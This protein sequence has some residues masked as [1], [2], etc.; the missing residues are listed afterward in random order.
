MFDA[1]YRHS[2]ARVAGLAMA[3]TDEQLASTVAAT[4]EWTGRDVVAHLVGVASDVATGNL[5][6][7][8]GPRWT[9]AQVDARAGR[10]VMDL[11]AE[12]D[13]VGPAMEAALAAR[14]AGIQSVLDVLTH[15]SD[16]RETFGFGTP[17]L[18][19]V[20]AATFPAIKGRVGGFGGPGSLQVR[21]VDSTGD[22]REWTGGDGPTTAVLTVEPYELFRGL[23][24]RR[25]R[26]QMRAWQWDG[27]TDPALVIEQ[28]P[29]FGCRD[30]DQPLP[31]RSP[32]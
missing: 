14:R 26:R 11:L 10:P 7:A 4:P 5:S 6:G 17:P 25:S 32:G 21:C 1:I 28:L 24:S 13:E 27:D 29:V 19:D 22:E 30:D 15:E 12:W 2:R 3:L 16:L 18:A 31:T 8:P 23:I 20:E 9:A